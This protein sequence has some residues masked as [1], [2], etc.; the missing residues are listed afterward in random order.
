MYSP[1]TEC[2]RHRSKCVVGWEG[3]LPNFIPSSR[4]AAASGPHSITAMQ[5]GD[6]SHERRPDWPP[7][8]RP[9]SS[10]GCDLGVGD[11][12]T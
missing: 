5:G 2:L 7:A 11:R 3:Q 4:A 9:T 1:K 10:L 6:V 12:R 8:A